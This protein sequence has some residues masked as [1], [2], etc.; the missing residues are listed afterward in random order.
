MLIVTCFLTCLFNASTDLIKF[1]ET[2]LRNC[3]RPAKT[4]IIKPKTNPKNNPI[5]ISKAFNRHSDQRS[6]LSFQKEMN[7]LLDSR[8]ELSAE[9]TKLQ[10]NP[11][12]V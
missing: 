11:A 8:L 3:S 1:S 10:T 9:L 12:S 7:D 5:K 6:R 2:S 4:P